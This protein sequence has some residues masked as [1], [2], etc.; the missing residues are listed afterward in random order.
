MPGIELLSEKAI[1]AAQPQAKA[2]K[3]RDGGGLF[4]R[5]TPAGSKRWGLSYVFA[6]TKK[7]IA[8]GEWPAVSKE[9][10]RDRCRHAQSLRAQ[11]ID[12]LADRRA[13]KLALKLAAKDS[14][15]NVALEWFAWWRAD[16]CPKH[17]ANV[18]KRLRGDILPALGARRMTE[19]ENPDLVGMLDAIAARGACDVARR[20]YQT[21]DQ[22]FRFAIPRRYAKH[23]PAGDAELRDILP[24]RKKGHFAKVPVA[25]LPELLRKM[26]NY[27]G[28]PVTRLALELLSLVWLRTREMIEGRWTE[29]D[30]KERLWRIPAERMKMDDEHLVPLSRQTLELL[31]DLYRL[32]GHGEWMFPHDRKP[33]R[34]MS[35]NT[36]LGALESMGYR[37][38]MTG[39]GWRALASTLLHEKGFPEAHIEVQLSHLKRDK[40][41]VAYDF[42]KYVEDRRKLMQAWADLLDDLR[43]DKKILAMRVNAG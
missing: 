30:W 38:R 5:V 6:G 34:H 2:Y 31:Q 39:H 29:I 19:I 42:A 36:I 33:E 7:A 28:M 40:V 43:G 15:E 37:G 12:P 27:H 11:G 9:L 4:L 22:I 17:V 21:V 3:L 16:K 10:A 14:F 1:R 13:K 18:E 25:E 23:N 35:N 24:Q 8:F 26:R 20:A 41:S 32:T